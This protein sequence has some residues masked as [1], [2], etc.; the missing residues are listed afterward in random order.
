M[1]AAT[2]GSRKILAPELAKLQA[3]AKPTDAA[4]EILQDA[5]LARNTAKAAFEAVA[6]KYQRYGG[7]LVKR[8]RLK[9]DEEIDQTTGVI[10][11]SPPKPKET[12]RGG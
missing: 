3:L 8:Y 11:K 7:F 1:S 12:S 4:Y 2:K 10:R 5:E 6:I 9:E